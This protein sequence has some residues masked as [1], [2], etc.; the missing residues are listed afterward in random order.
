MFYD[1]VHIFDFMSSWPAKPKIITFWHVY[2]KSLPTPDVDSQL[3]KVVYHKQ[4]VST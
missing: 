3:N 4:F 2:K 1:F